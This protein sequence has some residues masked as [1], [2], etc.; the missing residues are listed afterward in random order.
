MCL[1]MIFTFAR[2]LVRNGA[3][4][5][6]RVKRITVSERFSILSMMLTNGLYIGTS[7]PNGAVNEKMTSSAV[8]GL[9]SCHFISLLIVTSSVP[10]ATHAAFSVAH[11]LVEPFGLTLNN[12]F[13][14]RSFI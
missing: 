12:R 7:S 4:G 2:L 6:F 5:S 10:L 14:R 9:P 11:G 13:Q 8:T 1:G 3:Y